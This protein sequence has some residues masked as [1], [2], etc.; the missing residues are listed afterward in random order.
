M[1]WSKPHFLKYHTAGKFLRWAFAVFYFTQ[2]TACEDNT[3]KLGFIDDC[4]YIANIMG[5]CESYKEE[6]KKTC[7]FCG[8]NVM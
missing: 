3:D 5:Q 7:G 6:C 1:D 2:I 8:N 4:G